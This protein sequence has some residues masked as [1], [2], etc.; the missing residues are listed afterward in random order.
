MRHVRL[1]D[2][3]YRVR[4][5][6]DAQRHRRERG[7]ATPH[8]LLGYI[9]PENEDIVLEQA[10]PKTMSA[11]LFHEM[12]HDAFP[13][14]DEDVIRDAEDRLFPALWKHGFRPF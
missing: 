12:L 11:T 7:I 3:R 8:S 9:D 13:F 14:L 5:V 4:V 2:V 1:G 6:K 10:E